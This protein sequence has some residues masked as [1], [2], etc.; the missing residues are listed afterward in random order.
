MML[1]KDVVP[2]SMDVVKMVKLLEIQKDLTV[3]LKMS[4]KMKMEKKLLEKIFVI[5]VN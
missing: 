1:I 5:T 2:V 3:K 4:L